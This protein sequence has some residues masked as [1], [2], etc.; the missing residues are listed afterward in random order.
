MIADS[1]TA[2]ASAN[3]PRRGLMIDP[4]PGVTILPRRS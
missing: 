2:T 4:A 1:L 3:T